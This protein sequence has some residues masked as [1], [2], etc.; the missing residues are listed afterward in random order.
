[1][2][3]NMGV[4]EKGVQHIPKYLHFYLFSR[5]HDDKSLDLLAVG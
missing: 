3:H 4:S 5:E 1:M 2:A